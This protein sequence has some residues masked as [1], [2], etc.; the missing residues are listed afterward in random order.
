VRRR[1]WRA[2]EGQIRQRSATPAAADIRPDNPALCPLSGNSG[3][4]RILAPDCTTGIHVR[5]AQGTSRDV[6]IDP[7]NADIGMSLFRTIGVSL[8]DAVRH[9]LELVFPLTIRRFKWPASVTLCSAT[10]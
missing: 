9:E 1:R 7:F 2:I 6:L 8:H 5:H 4:I 3:Q 10:R